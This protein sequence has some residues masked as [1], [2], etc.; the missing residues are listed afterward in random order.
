MK[1]IVLMLAVL[2]SVS[3]PQA[4]AQPQDKAPPASTAQVQESASAE[5]TSRLNA[6]R[7]EILLVLLGAI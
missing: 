5:Q 3:A 7:S 1:S 2:L 4:F 6:I